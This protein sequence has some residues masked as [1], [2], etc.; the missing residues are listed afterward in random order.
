[1]NKASIIT[2]TFIALVCALIF[3]TQSFAEPPNLA[4]L[5]HEVTV[6]H[7]SGAYQKELNQVITQARAFIIARANANKHAT[8]PQKL[9]LVLD[10]DETSVSNYD[11]MVARGFVATKKQLNKEIIAADSPAIKPML[12]LYK[13]ALQ[14]G[15]NLF[16]VTGRQESL[17]VATNKNLNYAGYRGWSGLYLRPDNYS[18][19]SIIPFKSQTRAA[20][21]KNGYVIIASIGDQCSDLAGGFAEKTFKLPNP[22][23]YLP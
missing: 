10:I 14:H 22:Y 12:S 23:Y 16:F 11:K 13:E 5:A 21:M 20:I 1:M 19:P 17:R 4:Q 15:I 6:Y 8:H 2:N 7:D 9:A 3:N 18:K